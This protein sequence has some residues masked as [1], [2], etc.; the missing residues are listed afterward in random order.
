[1]CGGKWPIKL[2]QH[3]ANNP[4]IIVHGFKHAGIYSALG[5]LA[6]KDTIPD[7]Q[8]TDDSNIDN[9][10]EELTE[11]NGSDTSKHLA[12][13]TIYSRTEKEYSDTEEE[14]GIHYHFMFRK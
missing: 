4:H 10:I 11:P 13:A 3:L 14:T 8:A 9:K 7:Y 5:L 2:N 1:M 12:V 6:N